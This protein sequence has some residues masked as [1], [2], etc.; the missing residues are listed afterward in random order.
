MNTH[1]VL[2]VKYFVWS[3]IRRFIGVSFYHSS[4]SYTDHEIGCCSKQTKRYKKSLKDN[5][6]NKYIFL[7]QLHSYFCSIDR[8]TNQLSVNTTIQFGYFC[9]VTMAE[10]I[11]T[12]QWSSWLSTENGTSISYTALALQNI[13][14]R[15]PIIERKKQQDRK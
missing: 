1:R 14:F 15:K 11:R 5:K 13:R 6:H 7:L 10:E 12:Q 8:V 9:F 2:N 3:K 4:S